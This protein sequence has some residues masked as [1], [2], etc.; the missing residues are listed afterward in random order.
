[1][2]T[3]GAHLRIAEII[4]NQNPGYDPEAFLVGNIGP[5]CGMFTGE[6]DKFDPPKAVSHWKNEQNQ[7]IPEP[8][9]QKYLQNA[10]RSD[11]HRYSF[12]AGYFVHL[13]CDAAWTANYLKIKRAE[14]HEFKD[15]GKNPDLT[16]AVKND[17]YDQDQLYFTN[18]PD[19]VFNNIFCKIQS[20]P[21][22]LDY[23]PQGAVE[24]QMK[25]IQRFY[26][27]YSRDPNREYQYLT[28]VEM[29]NFVNTTAELAVKELQNRNLM[30][31]K[32]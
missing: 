28:T 5:D 10:D 24:F 27:T 21:D 32:F 6:W 14:L 25:E 20:F 18:N 1:M 22:Y 11:L 7:T 16:R 26:Q 17:W 8:F 2:A 23:F 15:F 4:L 9:Y 12:L 13:I 19:N 31:D 29:N 30:M 3:W